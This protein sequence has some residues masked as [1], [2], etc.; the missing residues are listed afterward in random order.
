MGRRVCSS[1]ETVRDDLQVTGEWE[2]VEDRQ[3]FWLY[4]LSLWMVIVE[5]VFV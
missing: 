1:G 5:Y 4:K 3:I 2:R